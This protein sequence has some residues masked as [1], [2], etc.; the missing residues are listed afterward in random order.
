[1]KVAVVIHAFGGRQTGDRVT[2]PAEIAG[3]LAG[4][5]AHRVVISDHD[6]VPEPPPAPEP[7]VSLAPPVGPTPEP[8]P[9]S[10]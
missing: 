8:E 7:A 2:D 3:I 4:E 6:D 10:G 5:Q 1:M 9:I